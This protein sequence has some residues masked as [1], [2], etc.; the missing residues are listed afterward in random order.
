M[1]AMRLTSATTTSLARN[2][3]SGD[4]VST[5][6]AQCP[7]RSGAS[8]RRS[9]P[10][11]PITISASAAGP[12]CQKAIRWPSGERLTCAPPS[13]GVVIRRIAPV[14]TSIAEMA[15]PAETIERTVPRARPS[16]DRHA[17]QD[18][19]EHEEQ[20]PHE[21]HAERERPDTS[22]HGLR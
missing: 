18:G 8:R 11:S 13:A 5:Q 7:V 1:T 10:S 9:C 19:D 12:D 4:H 22:M 17:G 14:S 16:P 6:P 2:R 21:R 20:Q 3:E 15:P